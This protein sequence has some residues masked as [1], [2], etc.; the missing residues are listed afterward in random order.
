MSGEDAGECNEDEKHGISAFSKKGRSDSAQ[1][2]PF[3]RGG[4]FYFCKDNGV[5]EF[6]HQVSKDA[7][8]DYAGSKAKDSLIRALSFP[9]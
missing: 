8:G 5:N 6:T 4:N 2:Q 7:C 1:P 3:A 9:S